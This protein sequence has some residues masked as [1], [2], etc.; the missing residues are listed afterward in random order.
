MGTPNINKKGKE[1]TYSFPLC[2]KNCKKAVE[3]TQAG[4]SFLF[5][6]VVK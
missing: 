1:S 6:F 5:V 2:K 4:F 3:D